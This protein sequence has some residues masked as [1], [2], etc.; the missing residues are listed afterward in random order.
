MQQ[1]TPR[2]LRKKNKRL[3]ESRDGLKERNREKAVENKRLSGKLD[4]IKVSREMWK[5][6]CREATAQNE[7]LSQELRST[8]EALEQEKVRTICLQ[9][10]V[11]E[12]K[13][14]AQR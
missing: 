11:L 10:E 7:A 1:E 14:K 9:E 8:Q 3:K 4:D 2:D 13:K 12:I 6:R 5:A